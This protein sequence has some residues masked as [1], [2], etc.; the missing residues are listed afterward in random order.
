MCSNNTTTAH[1]IHA[2]RSNSF[3]TTPVFRDGGFLFASASEIPTPISKSRG[4][5]KKGSLFSPKRFDAE[6]RDLTI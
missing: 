3:R 6:R 5:R 4:V 1:A 2:G